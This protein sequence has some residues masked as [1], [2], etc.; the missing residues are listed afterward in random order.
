MP[1][2]KPKTILLCPLEYGLDLFGG[3]WK[4]RVLCVLGMNG[5]MRFSALSR[6]LDN[7]TD[8]TLNTVLKE[9]VTEEMVCRIVY[10]EQPLRVEYS[11]T[12][13][14]QSALPI[15][16]NICG[17]SKTY[18]DVDTK[19]VLSPCRSCIHLCKTAEGTI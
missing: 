8:A 2:Q 17:W 6:E 3:K 19:N 12:E 15:L 4:C 11:L 13:K 7:I 18:A 5:P 1:N 10:D 9:M 14:A 16:Q